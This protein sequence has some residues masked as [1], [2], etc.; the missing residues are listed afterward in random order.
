M[1]IEIRRGS[2]LDQHDVEAIVNAANNGMRGGGGIDGAI[3]HAAGPGLLAELRELAP[4]GCPTGEV[5]VTGGH[6]LPFKNIFHTPGP[7]WKGGNRDEPD[8]LASCYRRC[9]EEADRLGLTSIGYCSIST[10]I[11]GYPIE[12]AAP[13]ALHTV[14]STSTGVEHVV[15]AMFGAAEFGAFN[16][17]LSALY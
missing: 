14:T 5:V 1:K 3:H 7:V 10:G 6:L 8:L 12:L 16:R 9:L 11:Y 2:L 15:F 17:A 13:V 4:N